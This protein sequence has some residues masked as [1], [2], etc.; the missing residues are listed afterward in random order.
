MKAR[1]SILAL[2]ILLVLGFMQGEAAA[3]F[4]KG[5]KLVALMN[6]YD[7]GIAGAEGVNWSDAGRYM[8]YIIGVYDALSQAEEL[9]GVAWSN[10]D[11]VTAGQACTIVSKYLKKHP[12]R[13]NEWAVTLVIDALKEAFPLPKKK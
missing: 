7:R 2:A 1:Q 10:P 13:W 8:G 4:Y 5:D 6:E 11:K 9:L 12:E 3:D